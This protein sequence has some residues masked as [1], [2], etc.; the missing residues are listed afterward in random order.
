[1]RG[2]V[3]Y[4]PHDVRFEQRDEPRIIKSADAIVRLA[5]T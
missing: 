3:L 1:M 2:A 4:G 5:A